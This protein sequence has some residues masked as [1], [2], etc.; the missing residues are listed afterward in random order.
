VWDILPIDGVASRAD[1]AVDGAVG[2]HGRIII[3]MGYLLSHRAGRTGDAIVSGSQILD[4]IV[5]RPST[6]TG[7]RVVCNIWCEPALDRVAL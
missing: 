2:D 7:L 5:D 1:V 3:R 6:E 4:D